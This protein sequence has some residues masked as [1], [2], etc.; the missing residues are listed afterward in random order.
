[1]IDMHRSYTLAF[2]LFATGLA[3][4]VW[5]SGCADDGGT[6]DGD[7]T[8]VPGMSEACTCDGGQM[9]AQVCEP[10]GTGF[11]ECSCNGGE[12]G[13]GNGDGDGDPTTG[14]GDGDGDPTTGDGDGDPTTGDGDG[15]DCNPVWDGESLPSWSCHIVPFFYQS[16]GAGVNGCHSREAFAATANQDCRGWLSL[17]DVPLGSEIYAPP[18]NAG[19]PTG[20][21]D[22]PLHD[23]L[24]TLAPWQCDA[25]SRYV[26]TAAN[27][28]ILDKMKGQNLCP[29]GN[30]PSSVMP[31]PDSMIVITQ[32]D[33]DM[34]EAWIEAGAPID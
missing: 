16:C 7:G 18:E 8:C 9:G 24:L 28:Y 17:E 30:M 23:R 26:D 4:S 20:C 10:D 22:M 33:I 32:M 12:T 11:G 15:D 31:P 5:V 1:M 3:T 13:D 14:D 6:A 21:P 25:S 34:I 27:S 19:T 2:L 29:N